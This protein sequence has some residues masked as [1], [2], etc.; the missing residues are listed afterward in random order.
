MFFLLRK[1]RLLVLNKTKLGWVYSGGRFF[2]V[3]AGRK[4]QV[5]SKRKIVNEAHL[6]GPDSRTG[7]D[8]LCKLLLV[9]Q[10]L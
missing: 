5:A 6:S 8:Q 2:D 9:G 4:L 1:V 3:K 10:R 7:N